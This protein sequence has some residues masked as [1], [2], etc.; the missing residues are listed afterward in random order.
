M[1]VALEVDEASNQRIDQ[2]RAELGLKPL[3]DGTCNHV[4]IAGVSSATGDAP[5]ALRQLRAEWCPPKPAGA[6]FP[7][8]M[9]ALVR[10]AKRIA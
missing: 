6:A 3:P 4:T 7:K 2:I 9:T 10:Q 1:Y 8:P 5:E